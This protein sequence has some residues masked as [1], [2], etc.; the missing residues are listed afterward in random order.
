MLYNTLTAMKNQ[1]WLLKGLLA[2][3]ALG[4]ITGTAT[5][6]QSSDVT[7]TIQSPESGEELQAGGFLTSGLYTETKLEVSDGTNDTENVD[8]KY[9]LTSREDSDQADTTLEDYV[10][11]KNDT[12]EI[13]EERVELDYSYEEEYEDV[14][15]EVTGTYEDVDD[16]TT[17]SDSDSVD[18]QVRKSQSFNFIIVVVI[19][20]A[21]LSAFGLNRS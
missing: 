11:V 15:L 13:V 3:I 16:T 7:T 17:A 10:D 14:T 5:A 19:I 1:E 21:M 6:V 12:S 8:I 9:N 20:G 2:F 4:F 18:F